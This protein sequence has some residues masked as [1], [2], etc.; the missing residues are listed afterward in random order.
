MEPDTSNI[1]V[2][3]ASGCGACQ[4]HTPWLNR[5]CHSTQNNGRCLELRALTATWEFP[6]TRGP[7][8]DTHK[9][10]LQFPE[11]AISWR[12]REDHSKTRGAFWR[13]ALMILSWLPRLMGRFKN[14][15]HL[16]LHSLHYRRNRIRNWRIYLLLL[17]SSQKSG[18]RVYV[19]PML[20][21]TLYNTFL[22][23]PIFDLLRDGITLNY[24]LKG[25]TWLKW[26]L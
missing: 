3:E 8:I 5:T 24:P 12:S 25:L 20:E 10:D 6:K 4:W 15:S 19:C 11:T 22:I 1:W 21:R 26:I 2:L 14:R 18:W 9:T 16:G 23:Y 17:A 7:H 13:W